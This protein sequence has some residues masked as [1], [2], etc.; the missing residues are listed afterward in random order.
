MSNSAHLFTVS[1]YP[2]SFLTSLFSTLVGYP[3]QLLELD[4]ICIISDDF[5]FWSDCKSHTWFYN[6]RFYHVKTESALELPFY[7]SGYPRIRHGIVFSSVCLSIWNNN[8]N[9]NL[10]N[11]LRQAAQPYTRYYTTYNSLLRRA[12][13]T[14]HKDCNTALTLDSLGLE[15][16]F[17]VYRYIFRTSR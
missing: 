9:N 6:Y 12:A 8:N 17:E 3:I 13:L 10:F 2:S 14:R 16:L 7:F 11:W 4:R 5:R 15:S 1:K